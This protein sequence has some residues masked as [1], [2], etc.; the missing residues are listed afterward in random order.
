MIHEFL[1]AIAE[2]KPFENGSIEDG[3]RAAQVLE[4]IQKASL[5]NSPV[6]VSWED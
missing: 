4:A 1:T 2:D 5:T 3:F 6:K